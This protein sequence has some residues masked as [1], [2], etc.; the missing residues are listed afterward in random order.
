[1]YCDMIEEIQ[2]DVKDA[3]DEVFKAISKRDW[4]SFVLLVGRADI[5]LNL[6]DKDLIASVYVIDDN[7][8]L[9]Y[10]NTRKKFWIRYMNRIYRREGFKYLGDNGIDDLSIEMMIYSHLWNS[11]YHLKLLHRISSILSGRGYEWN[12]KIPETGMHKWIYNDIITPLKENGYKLG[13]I[14]AK[15]Y[16]SS[17][18]NAF[19]HS[20]YSI[21]EGQRKIHIR[22]SSS[23]WEIISFDEFQRLFLYSSFIMNVLH[24]SI[25]Y[26]FQDMTLETRALT[27]PFYTP[28]NVKVQ[29]FS[30]TKRVG[31][32][33]CSR[34]RMIKVE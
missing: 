4:L 8:D 3:I 31:G 10:D 21:Y 33:L 29:V 11:D 20:N 17:I 32:T 19:A 30:E 5:D 18:R 24:N 14:I 7:R 1:M 9:Y 27:E 28:D 12:V 6:K 26:A 22:P 13:E 34:M 15:G 16:K 23:P 25:E 2:R